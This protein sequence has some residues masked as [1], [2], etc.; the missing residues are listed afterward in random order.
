MGYIQMGKDAVQHR[1]WMAN[2]MPLRP[3]KERGRAGAKR[4]ERHSRTLLERAAARSLHV[5]VSAARTE[6]SRSAWRTTPPK[7]TRPRRSCAACP[8]LALHPPCLHPHTTSIEQSSMA[9]VARAC[10]VPPPPPDRDAFTRS[11]NHGQMPAPRSLHLPAARTPL[12][13]I[14]AYIRTTSA[15]YGH[16]GPPPT[17]RSTPRRPVVSRHTPM[18]TRR[19]PLRLPNKSEHDAR[20]AD[21]TRAT[22][23]RWRSTAGE[24]SRDSGGRES[25]NRKRRRWR[26]IGY[27]EPD[28]PVFHRERRRR[29]GPPPSRSGVTGAKRK[30]PLIQ[31]RAPLVLGRPRERVRQLGCLDSFEVQVDRP[32]SK[33][34]LPR[35]VSLR[36][37]EVTSSRARTGAIRIALPG[38]F[39]DNRKGR[40]KISTAWDASGL[41]FLE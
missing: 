3:R 39:P 25:E 19:M 41:E 6:L 4:R 31:P 32:V 13:R 36:V 5:R 35:S 10:R 2:W 34:V 8:M 29:I 23:H 40:E 38:R 21:S 37:L 1:S 22:P 28:T 24:P 33:E 14:V 18:Q 7:R 30:A 15:A 27:R 9:G 17:Q 16:R 11:D 26:G 20:R 12:G